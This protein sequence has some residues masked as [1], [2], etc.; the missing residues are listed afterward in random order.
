MDV[1]PVTTTT[2]PPAPAAA[3]ARKEISS[4]FETFL[5]MLT[6]QLQNQDPLN[7]IESS[8]YAVQL[9]TFSGVEQQVQTN[10]LL[11]SLIGQMGTGGM[12]QLAGWV[13]KEARSGAGVT[14]SGSPVTLS[15][16]PNLSADTAQLV[17]SDSEGTELQRLPIDPRESEVVWAGVTSDGVPLPNG[18]YKI[19][20]VA[21]ALGQEV[22]RTPASTYAR[23]TE[24]QSI[25]G[26]TRL[27]LANGQTI[28]VEDV[29]AVRE[30]VN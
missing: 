11:K 4:D 19:E 8:D 29:T 6:V 12:A 26:Q 17:I 13:G 14:F 18:T 23:I 27:V 3:P 21:S 25:A 28:A 2:P 24:V 30:A 10:E 16:V 1:S 15:V 9:A 7:P 20:V 22:A 5:T